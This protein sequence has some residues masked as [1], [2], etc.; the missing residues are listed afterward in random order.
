MLAKLKKGPKMTTGKIAVT[1][2]TGDRMEREQQHPKAEA[3]LKA[4]RK[5]TA[6]EVVEEEEEVAEVVGKV[7]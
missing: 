6:K 7:V 1:G 5:E 3:K 2:G 4:E